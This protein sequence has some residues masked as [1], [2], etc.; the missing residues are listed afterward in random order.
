M[1]PDFDIYHRPSRTWRSVDGAESGD[2]ACRSLG[3]EPAGCLIRPR[4][5]GSRGVEHLLGEQAATWYQLLEWVSETPP[6]EADITGDAGID[7]AARYRI[8]QQIE[9]AQTILNQLR[10]VIQT[11]AARPDVIGLTASEAVMERDLPGVEPWPVLRRTALALLLSLTGWRGQQPQGEGAQ[12]VGRALI[13]R[14]AQNESLSE[15]EEKRL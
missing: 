4:R 5:P 14:L 8:R 11:A 3:W 15:E 13:H 12:R 2:D 1:A 6:R 7:R 9:G 10:P